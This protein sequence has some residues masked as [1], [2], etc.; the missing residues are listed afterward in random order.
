MRRKSFVVATLV[1][2]FLSVAFVPLSADENTSRATQTHDIS[3]AD[4]TLDE[5]SCGGSCTYK[6]SG[7]TVGDGFFAWENAN[8]IEVTGGNH[9]IILNN[10]S[11]DER[12][13]V[14]ATNSAID[15]RNGA[16]LTLVLKGSNTLYGYNNHPA[17]WVDE[18]STLVIEGDGSLESHA[19]ETTPSMGA[20]GIGGGYNDGNFGNIIIN[21]GTITSYGSGGG[22]G[23]GGGYDVGSGDCSGNI[24]INGG[25]VKAYGGQVGLLSSAGAGIGAGENANYTGT[26]TINGGVVFAKS[27]KDDMPSIGGG[28]RITGSTSHGTFVTGDDGNAVI[29][30]PNGIGANQNSTE[31][32]GIFISYGGDENSATVKADGTVLINDNDANIQVWGDVVLDYDLEIAPKTYFRIIK[33]DRNGESSSLRI[34]V[35]HKLINNGIIYLGN[36]QN[37]PSYLILNKGLDQTSGSGSLVVTGVAKVKLPLSEGLV[38][39][40]DDVTYNG[41]TQKPN[42]SVGFTGLWGYSQNFYEGSD[43]TRSDANNV[44]AGEATVTL[45]A[46]GSGNLLSGTVTKTYTIHPADFNLGLDMTWAIKAGETNLKLPKE[47][48]SIA[49]N[50]KDDMT[51]LKNGTLTWYLDKNMTIPL[52]ADSLKDKQVGD[53]VTVYAKYEHG[54]TNFVNPKVHEMTIRVVEFDVHDA[55][56]FDGNDNVTDTTISKEYSLDKINLTAKID[57]KDNG[58]YND[59]LSLPV[60][61]ESD[62]ES[63]VSV[64]QNGVVTLVGVGNATITATI[65][66][67]KTGDEATSYSSVSAEVMIEVT[68]RTVK[69]DEN[70][71]KI[72]TRPYDGTSEVLATAE[73]IDGGIINNDD[74]SLKVTATLD[75]PNAGDD[76][77]VNVT[78]S[79]EGA[80]ADNYILEPD[81]GTGIVTISKAD[82]KDHDVSS[83]DGKLAIYNKTKRTYYFALESLVNDLGANY[84]LGSV[85]YTIKDVEDNPYFTKDNVSV[86]AG[87]YLRVDAKAVDS[88]IEGIVANIAINITSQNYEPMSA[89][90]EVSSLNP[91]TE[92]PDEPVTEPDDPQGP[93]S[94]ED[95]E[96]TIPNTQ[97]KTTKL[98]NYFAIGGLALTALVITIYLKKKEN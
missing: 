22:A 76:K 67:H 5:N 15:V 28:G 38:S 49:S 82:P 61:W 39:S 13:N 70:T 92:E 97:S 14:L 54:D 93:S 50:I 32:N 80:D 58:N 30:A 96:I 31:W 23:I 75:D 86:V 71:L 35:D 26:I 94:E 81:G 55:A 87:S 56:I 18:N 4:L 37:D 36:D 95:T 98:V 41:Q 43:Y 17:I 59:P 19:G 46:T 89:N 62:D 66:E 42:V 91:S 9:T 51:D 53:E 16:T 2:M 77:T 27:G 11:I 44:N 34:D 65:P 90:I 72:E 12:S 84:S 57:L 63:V 74:A 29:V 78:Y 45:I 69:V 68:K 52:E 73:L 88:D 7:S 40:L 47:N 60:V 83:Q 20:A 24:T 64:D 10:V 1:C 21:S 85:S 8:K 33:N 3:G 79:L 25:Y 6:V 48:L